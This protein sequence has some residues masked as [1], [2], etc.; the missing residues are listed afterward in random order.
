MEIHKTNDGRIYATGK[1]RENETELISLMLWDGV[2]SLERLAAVREMVLFAYRAPE[3]QED[4]LRFNRT[5]V[6][7]GKGKR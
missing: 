1:L 7:F 3:Q 2:G 5:L 4:A 6:T